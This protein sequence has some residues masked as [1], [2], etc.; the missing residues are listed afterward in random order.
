MTRQK[1]HNVSWRIG[2][3]RDKHENRMTIF[4]MLRRSRGRGILFIRDILGIW[5]VYATA[6]DSAAI[7]QHNDGAGFMPTHINSRN[8]WHHQPSQKQAQ[9]RVP[10]IAWNIC[11]DSDSQLK[12]V[13]SFV[14]DQQFS[15]A[16]FCHLLFAI[17]QRNCIMLTSRAAV[18]RLGDLWIVDFQS[19]AA[20]WFCDSRDSSRATN[21]LKFNFH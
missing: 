4:A 17:R 9:Y 12:G 11:P 10:N 16:S 20:I 5:S 14:D 2:S 6:S 21:S 3:R 15:L 1:E 18:S 19:F 7:K 13:K 8:C